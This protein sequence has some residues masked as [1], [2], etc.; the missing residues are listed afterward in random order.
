MASSVFMFVEF[1][2]TALGLVEAGSCEKSTQNQSLRTLEV[3]ASE[4][5]RKSFCSL[6]E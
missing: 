1:V 3:D 6:N 2:R 5:D 4:C